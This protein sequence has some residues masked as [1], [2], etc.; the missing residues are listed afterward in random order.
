MDMEAIQHNE[1]EVMI[2]IEHRGFDANITISSKD[3][4]AT[5]RLMYNGTQVDDGGGVSAPSLEK[6]QELFIEKVDKHIQS[7]K[8]EPDVTPE[9]VKALSDQHLIERRERIVRNTL[10][11]GDRGYD[12][13][14]L[15]SLTRELMLRDPDKICREWN[16]L[17]AVTIRMGGAYRSTKD[18]L[19]AEVQGTSEQQRMWARNESKSR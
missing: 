14:R 11:R 1:E 7:T 16:H 4:S 13:R 19:M 18:E 15:T 2:Q 5:L 9:L 10:D 17:F 12:K 3:N 6:A 8:Q